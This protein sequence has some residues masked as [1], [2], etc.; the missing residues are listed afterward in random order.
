MSLVNNKRL[1]Q[2]F[3]DLVSIDCESYQEKEM[4]T[5]LKEKLDALQIPYFEDNASEFLK[6]ENSA[7]NLYCVLKGNLSEKE[8]M[9][10]AILFSSHMDTVKPGIGKKAI[11]H[12]DGKITSDGTTVLGA[13]DGAG[14]AEIL[15]MLTILIEN[16]LPHPDIEILFASAEE[17]YCQ[18][19]RYVDYSKFHAKKAYVLDL[20]GEIGRAANAAPSIYSLYIKVKG[21]SS[22]AGFA[23][24]Q[25][26]HALYIASKAIA[27]LPYGSVEEGTTIN[28]GTVQGG[29]GK[30]I[31]PDEVS[32]SGE[33]RSMFKEKAE[34][35]I[36]QMK[37]TFEKQ[38]K[39]LN[40]TVEFVV[41][42]EFDAYFVDEQEEVSQLFKLACE[43]LGLKSTLLQTFGGS[44][45]NN[46]NPHGIKGLVLANAMNEVHSVREWTS[47]QDMSLCVDILLQIIKL[48]C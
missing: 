33:V 23:P 11:V 13:D 48:S 22:H 32:L 2:T 26:V 39:L 29:R 27:S 38:A 34:Y 21:K 10:K 28:I 45:N 5:F 4:A 40:G 18:G 41:E 8:N 35:W 9:E 42:K 24:E 46:I 37:Q 12:A 20:S 15:E 43:N 1:T 6:G 36:E 31:V 14:L 47:I 25:G 7:N 16:N 3:L 30:N 19:S 17:P 44:D